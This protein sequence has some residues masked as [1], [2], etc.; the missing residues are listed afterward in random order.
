MFVGVQGERGA[1][2]LTVGLNG[3]KVFSN[4]NN[5]VMLVLVIISLTETSDLHHPLAYTALCHLS[6]VLR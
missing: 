1:I 2:G 5:S 6:Y 4:L 3:L